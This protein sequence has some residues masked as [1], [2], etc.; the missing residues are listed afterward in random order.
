MRLPAGAEPRACGCRLRCTLA[1]RATRL[2]PVATTTA[3]QGPDVA[4]ALQDA[5]G[6]PPL[7]TAILQQVLH[8]KAQRLAKTGWST[9]PD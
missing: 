2:D 5:G 3:R 9:S 4:R 6:V 1:R 8:A 7:V